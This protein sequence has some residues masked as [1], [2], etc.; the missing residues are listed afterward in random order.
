MCEIQ[1]RGALRQP[2]LAPIDSTRASYDGRLAP[3]K[4]FADYDTAVSLRPIWP[5]DEQLIQK[6]VKS[7]SPETRHL[8]FMDRL[9]ELIPMT[10]ARLTHVDYRRDMAIAALLHKPGE[11]E[12][13][14]V[15]RYATDERGDSCE[16]ALVLADDWQRRGLGRYL[17]S[18]L[19]EIARKQ[20]LNT[21]WGD[22]SDANG[23]MFALVRS[24]GFALVPSPAG[25]GLTR[26]TLALDRAI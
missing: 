5:S 24:L 2:T 6:F 23:S 10:L 19:I 17:L 20:G 13:I 8:C 9:H 3:R 16:I 22:V 15:G 14:A 4:W 26:A 11:D 21:M 1:D 7:L 25:R 12:L 18:R